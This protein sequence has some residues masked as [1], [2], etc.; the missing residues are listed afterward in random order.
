MKAV[1]KRATFVTFVALLVLTAGSFA[2][3]YVPLGALNVPVALAIATLKATLVVAIFMELAV[4][5]FTMKLSLV[6]GFVFVLLL[7]GLMVADVTTRAAPPLLP[8]PPS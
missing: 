2:I 7:V 3:S 6:M 5:K 8:F 1:S 4:E